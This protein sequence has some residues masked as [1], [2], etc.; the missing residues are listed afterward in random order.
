[1]MLSEYIRV[2]EKCI[3]EEGDAEC[4]DEDGEPIGEPEFS[5]A[6]GSEPKAWVMAALR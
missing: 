2:L 3:Q 6:G 1:M 4:V 5:P